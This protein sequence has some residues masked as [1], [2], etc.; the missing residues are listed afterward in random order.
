MGAGQKQQPG[1]RTEEKHRWRE[2]QISNQQDD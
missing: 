1:Q 2:K